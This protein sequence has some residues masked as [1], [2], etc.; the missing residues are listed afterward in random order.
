MRIQAGGV[1]P[2]GS[3][4]CP[5]DTLLNRPWRPSKYRLGSRRGVRPG[6][7][8]AQARHIPISARS[9][10][11]A[12]HFACRPLAFA[13]SGGQAVNLGAAQLKDGEPAWQATLS[14][15]TMTEQGPFRPSIL[16]GRGRRYCQR[17]RGQNEPPASAT[18]TPMMTTQLVIHIRDKAT[19]DQSA[20]TTEASKAA[21]GALQ[22]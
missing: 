3:F 17:G 9:G 10:P 4:W 1:Q 2:Y 8:V 19:V 22:N 7:T 18:G 16:N 14:G 21:S 11:A 12:S 20:S 5:R 6:T 15:L 13:V